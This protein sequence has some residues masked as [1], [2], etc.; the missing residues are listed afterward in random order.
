MP[1]GFLLT[2]Q[3]NDNKDQ[4]TIILFAR[5]AMFWEIASE[6]CRPTAV[7][8]QTSNQVNKREKERDGNNSKMGINAKRKL[9]TNVKGA[10]N[11]IIFIYSVLRIKLLTG[12][13]GQDRNAYN[14]YVIFGYFIEFF[15]SL[16][17]LISATVWILTHTKMDGNGE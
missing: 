3:N 11:W 16:L 8:S 10:K 6:L 17:F 9:N 12:A 4:E 15:C 5:F 7:T 14:L 2:L 1:F 13:N